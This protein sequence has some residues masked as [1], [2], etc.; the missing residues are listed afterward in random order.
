MTNL[1]FVLNNVHHRIHYLMCHLHF[2]LVDY[3]LMNIW[4][5]FLQ[6]WIT[7]WWTLTVVGIDI[8]IISSVCLIS[9]VDIQLFWIN[10]NLPYTNIEP[11]SFCP[12]SRS[13]PTKITQHFYLGEELNFLF[14]FDFG[15]LFHIPMVANWQFSSKLGEMFISILSTITF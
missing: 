7:M 11:I 14:S 4:F 5:L 13:F 8:V 12:Y 6:S 15:L 10:T 2:K 1:S 9:V 3:N